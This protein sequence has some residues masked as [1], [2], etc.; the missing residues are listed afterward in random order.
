M[1]M[2]DSIPENTTS[3]VSRAGVLKCMNAMA[4]EDVE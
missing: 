4:P 2:A 3:K 1:A